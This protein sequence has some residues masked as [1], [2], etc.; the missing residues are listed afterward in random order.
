[1]AYTAAELVNRAWYLSGIVGRNLETV[2][3]QQATDG[4]FLLNTLL[5]FKATDLRL[6]PYYKRYQFSM[7]AGQ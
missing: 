2:S 7:V 4:L 3:G 5:S 6:I 1:M